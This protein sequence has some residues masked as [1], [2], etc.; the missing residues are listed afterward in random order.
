[1]DHSSWVTRQKGR[2][3]WRHRRAIRF[4]S[5]G[6]SH[7]GMA[8]PRSPRAMQIWSAA[9]RISS[10][11][12]TPRRFSILAMICTPVSPRSSRA[13]RR[14]STSARPRTK[15]WRMWVAPSSPARS[16][17]ARSSSVRAGASTSTPRMA[18]LFRL[19]RVPPRSTR[20][21]RP[22][23]VFSATSSS[24]ALSSRESRSPG[25]AASRA[26]GGMGTPSPPS[27]TR[28]PV[29]RDR[30]AGSRPT[31]S[32]G[33]WR[34]RI[35]WAPGR[36]ARRAAGRKAPSSRGRLSARATW[37]RFSRAPVI[38]ARNRAS[39]VSGDEQAGPRV[40]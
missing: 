1:M 7:R 12:S 26:A 22:S 3:A 37:D 40:A 14:A 25:R 35:R 11:R 32:S 33:P 6:S 31:R 39:R 15:G 10:S 38:P 24:R 23:P 20:Q 36:P 30:G 18:R 9:S 5:P 19:R 4:W 27:S 21:T 2:P 16:R 34:S 13:R 8:L 28:P 29:S 17:L